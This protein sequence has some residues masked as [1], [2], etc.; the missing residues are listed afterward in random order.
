MNSLHPIQIVP[1]LLQVQDGRR[2]AQI[3]TQQI[4]TQPSD[5]RR[6]DG[7]LNK[8]DPFIQG[9]DRGNSLY[10]LSSSIDG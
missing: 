3:F 7:V 4:P 10:I 6:R 8:S 2:Q 9:L 1:Q 5:L